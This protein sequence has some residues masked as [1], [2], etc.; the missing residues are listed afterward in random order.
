MSVALAHLKENRFDFVH[1]GQ[2]VFRTL[3]MAMA[4][5]GE[6]K[7]LDEIPICLPHAE[8][9][10]VMQALLTLL[11]LETSFYLHCK[12]MDLRS[13][14]ESYLE[15]STNASNV[16][17]SRADFVL[18]I[19]P[20]LEGRFAELKRGT[21]EMPHT[22][23]TVFYLADRILASPSATA[24]ELNLSGPGV[25]SRKSLY[26]EGIAQNEVTE[27]RINR[28]KFPLGI[29]LYIVSRRGQIIG[30]PRSATIHA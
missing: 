3:M 2:K 10:F 16:N 22:S 8:Y 30:I 26:I 24:L 5:P 14:I 13:Q 17:A 27:W 15:I 20:S 23:A 19:G 21:L 12:D 28:G 29:D 7:T 6:I 18:C 11:D 4:F 25:K 1:N 9:S